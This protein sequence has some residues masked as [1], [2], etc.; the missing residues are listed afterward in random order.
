MTNPAGFYTC[1]KCGRLNAGAYTKCVCEETHKKQTACRLDNGD[2]CPQLFVGGYTQVYEQ[3][4]KN[5]GNLW[6][7]SGVSWI[8]RVIMITRIASQILVSN[9]QNVSGLCQNEIIKR[10]ENLNDISKYIRKNYP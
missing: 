7:T 8:T 6:K 4:W 10:K 1:P 2:I 9:T 3:M 5:P